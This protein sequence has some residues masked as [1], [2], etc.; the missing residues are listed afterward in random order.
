MI[1]GKNSYDT[2]KE[3]ISAINGISKREGQS[4]YVYKCSDCEKFH[5]S[6]RGKKKM[7]QMKD[8]KYPMKVEEMKAAKQPATKTKKIRQGEGKSVITEGKMMSQEQSDYLKSL[9]K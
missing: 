3:A 9:F 6:T 7:R 4:M 2:Y 5:L 1:C 8:G